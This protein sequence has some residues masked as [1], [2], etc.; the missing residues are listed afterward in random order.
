MVNINMVTCM[1]LEPINVALRGLCVNHF[2]NRP[3]LAAPIRFELMLTESES[4]AL[5]L[6]DTPMFVRFSLFLVGIDGFE[7]SE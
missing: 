5:P 6:G 3:N 7:P 1:G 4:V 2:T